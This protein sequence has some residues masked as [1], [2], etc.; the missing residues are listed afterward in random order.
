MSLR[1][2][3]RL[4]GQLNLHSGFVMVSAQVAGNFFAVYLLKS[5][6]SLTLTFLALAAVLGVRFALRFLV[7]WLVPKLGLRR[8]LA[9]GTLVRALQFIPLAFATHPA[10][11]VSWIALTALADALYWPLYHAVVAAVGEPETRG[12]QV[13]GLEAIRSIAGIVGP[14]LGGWLMANSGPEATFA[15]G[16]VLQL[17]ALWPLLHMPEIASGPVPK[18]RHS[19]KGDTIGFLIFVSDGLVQIGWGFVW[20]LALFTTLKSSFEIYGGAMALS[21]LVAAIL[22]F[23]AGRVLDLGHGGRLLMVVTVLMLLGIAA[24]ILAIGNGPAAFAVNAF[25]VVATSLYTPTIM[26]TMYNRA[27]RLGPLSF[28][29]FTES[30]WDIGGILGCLLAALVAALGG[31]MGYAMLPS[32]LGMLVIH[33]CVTLAERETRR[34]RPGMA[35]P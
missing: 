3:R 33:R 30:G 13:G 4:A 17:G 10:G 5:G 25:S 23:T 27:H 32:F 20:S 14:A 19:L 34:L 22:A 11:L 15:I 35:K 2:T 21:G 28:H 7:L 9:L 31:G 18:A 24:R 16:A 29:F 26:S 6:L 1:P 8:S 12:R